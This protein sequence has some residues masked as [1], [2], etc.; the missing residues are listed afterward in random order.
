MMRPL[1]ILLIHLSAPLMLMGQ[2][3][4]VAALR[5][6]QEGDLGA[7]RE[8]IDS[9]VTSLAHENDAEAWLLRGFVYKDLYKT[10]AP[11]P[12]SLRAR[13]LRSLD[14]CLQL[15][16]GGTYRSNALQAY[17]FVAR[18]YFNDAARA[19]QA[20]DEERAMAQFD[21]FT[22]AISEHGLETE[23]GPRRVEFLNALG[24]SFTKRYN[25][26]REQHDLFDRAVETYRQVLALAPDNY[27]ANYN[28]ATLFYNRGVHNIQKLDIDNDIPSIQKIQEVSKELFLEALPYMQKAHE[29][30]PERRETLLGLE[31]IYYSLQDDE[32]S[33]EFRLKFE[34]LPPDQE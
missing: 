5:A 6:Y 18:S 23:L 12:D 21:R 4:L 2:D 30:R 33:E 7:A 16:E 11:W 29:M 10:A 1:I 32:R 19:L 13:S 27:G 26:D 31:G 34:A 8:F 14:R 24:T 3:P 9:A 17:E 28:L 15:D 22:Q 20:M 25:E